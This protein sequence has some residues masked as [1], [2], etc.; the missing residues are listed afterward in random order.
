LPA[1]HCNLGSLL[2]ETGDLSG[3]ESCFRTALGLDQRLPGAREQLAHL[4]RARLPEAD[5]Q[6]TR[7]LLD[8]STLTDGQRGSLHYGLAQV[9]DAR[10][11]YQQA[12]AHAQEANR[13][14]AREHERRG[15]IY[16]PANH[17]HFVDRLIKAFSPEFF[18]RCRALGSDSIRPIFIVGLPRS[19]TTLTEQILACHSQ[20][21][22]GGELWLGRESFD[23]LAPGQPEVSVLEALADLDQDKIQHL[24]V[25]HLARLREL[26]VDLPHVVD[27]MPDNY[28]YLGLLSVLFPQA[29]FIHCRRDLRDVAVSCWMTHFRTI[30][31]ANCQENLV[32]RFRD[33]H[34]LMMHWQRVLPV[35][36]LEINYEET[37]ADLEGV[38]R[39]LV[40]WC[41]LEW[42]P[43]CLAFQ[44]G[45]R[46]VRTAS[47]S[48]VRQPLYSRSVARWKH[49]E[50]ALATLFGRLVMVSIEEP[51]R[52]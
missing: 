3:A 39:R 20:V 29:R 6:A 27:K 41:G 14:T 44:E 8:D 52:F 48:Q 35:A 50:P 33:Y 46:S 36:V 40:R 10:G 7:T 12:A 17:T 5:V 16:D 45:T 34:R 1:A 42:E 18:A 11:E 4:L 24:A 47:V 28:L 9:H 21:F 22:G 32:A 37:V 25:D 43:A 31:W 19:G 38:A 49:Y 23:A 15:E 51:F 30:R 26:N 2:E 13:L